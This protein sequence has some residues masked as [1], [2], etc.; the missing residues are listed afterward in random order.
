MKK[1]SLSMLC[2][3]WW[4][5]SGCTVI[6]LH[7]FEPGGVP[8]PP[9]APDRY[10]LEV[11]SISCDFPELEVIVTNNG[12]FQ[13]PT[14][15]NL[16]IA[17]GEDDLI[18]VILDVVPRLRKNESHTYLFDVSVIDGFDPDLLEFCAGPHGCIVHASVDTRQVIVESDEVNNNLSGACFGR[19]VPAGEAS[20]G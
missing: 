12:P 17:F 11:S 14:E 13:L 16:W 20:R 18:D 15:T 4:A 1:S 19:Q 8:I 2:L 6:V 3:V 10:D 5:A 7:K 9:L